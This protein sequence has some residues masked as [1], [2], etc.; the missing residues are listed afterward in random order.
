MAGNGSVDL[1]KSANT[2]TREAPRGLFG[3]FLSLLGSVARYFQALGA[4]AGEESKE[5]LA[6][7]LRLLVMLLAALFFA[8]FG[9]VLLVIAVA[10]F[11]AHV[12]GISWLW[13]LGGF[14]ALHLI[15]AFVCANHVKTH[16]HTPIFE[17]TRREIAADLESLR[18]NPKP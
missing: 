9:Y 10:F 1:P 6:L 11:A 17:A 4:L 12:L 18:K 2:G 14:T 7:G 5:A 8:A 15:I 16:R 13:I 3:E